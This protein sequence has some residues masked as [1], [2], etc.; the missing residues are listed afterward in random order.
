MTASPTP[1]RCEERYAAPGNKLAEATWGN[2]GVG[3]AMIGNAKGYPLRAPLSAAIPL[4][5]RT[6][7]R[8]LAPTV[9]STTR[10]AR[11][12]RA[13]GRDRDR[14]RD[15]EAT[16]FVLLD[17][18]NEANPGA[19]FRT[20]A[21]DLAADRGSRHALH[22]QSWHLRHDHGHGPLSAKPESCGE[23]S[24]CLSGGRPRYSRRALQASALLDP[25][26]LPAGIQRPDRGYRP[27]SLRPLPPAQP[28]GKHH[29][30]AELGL[31]LAGAPASAR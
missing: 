12:R 5:K 3:L 26:L 4:E 27:P 19:H 22:C 2:T 10:S 16:G 8:F 24:R 21:R 28:P 17:H 23:G 1:S 25:A 7:L 15:G 9:N 20:T 6:A 31:A 30:R 13:R 18:L 14:A 29:C 11:T